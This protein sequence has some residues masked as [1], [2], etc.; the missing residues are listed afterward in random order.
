MDLTDREVKIFFTDKE[1]EQEYRYRVGLKPHT[2]K[3]VGVD[4]ITSQEIRL[5]L[6]EV[7]LIDFGVII[8]VPEDCFAVIVPRSSL[9]KKYGVIQTN[10]F[11]VIDGDYSGD[12]DVLKMSVQCTGTH[13]NGRT[14]KFDTVIPKH[15]RVA[16]LFLLPKITFH[17]IPCREHWG[18]DSRG[19]FGSTGE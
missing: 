18:D 16:Q 8:K 1:V 6:G 15:T 10:H 17:M 9:F 4:L 13:S 5:N 11:G 14:D 3:S 12:T 19:G 7:T 2:E